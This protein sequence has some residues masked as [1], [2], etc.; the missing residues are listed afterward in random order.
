MRKLCIIFIG[1]IAFL[2]LAAQDNNA[3]EPAIIEFEKTKHDFGTVNEGGPITYEFKFTNKGKV[4][5]TITNVKASC[6]CTT[7]GWTKEPVQPGKTGVISA[8]YNTV[9]R[10]GAF[11][12]TVTVMANTEPAMMVLTITGN[13]LPRV[14]TPEEL[15]PKKVGSLRL[16]SDYVYL[17][18][19]TTKEP[20]YKEVDVYNEGEAP[21]Q[22]SASDLPAHVEVTFEPQTLN[23]KEKGKIKLKYDGLKRNELGPVQDDVVITTNEKSDNKK[24]LHIVA[25]INEYYP[26]LSAEE[27]A[28][29]PKLSAPKRVE[30]GNIKV[31]TTGSAEVEI[32]NTGK[33]DLV[34][35][36][37]RSAAGHI[38]VK[39]DKTTIKAGQSTKLKI[40]YKADGA[41]RGDSQFIWIYSN[42]PTSP[43]QSILVNAAVVQ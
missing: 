30:V 17:G 2:P 3:V 29:A 43:T 22:F 31:N 16:F 9:N 35:K 42:D 4:P 40:T 41:V 1:L 37:V 6:G 33:Q 8:Q 24:V 27:A 19:F 39:A 5:L 15:Y 21:L 13:V 28:N 10:P 18:K 34:L 26:P 12:K 20:M 14:K 23:S 7:P 32:T 25:D 11:T 36:K 38:T